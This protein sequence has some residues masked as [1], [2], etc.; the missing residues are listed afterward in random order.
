MGFEGRIELCSRRVIE[1]G[2]YLT[3]IH[4]RG[5]TLGFESIGEARYGR[6]IV[7]RTSRDEEADDEED[8]NDQDYNS[9]KKFPIGRRRQRITYARNVV[10]PFDHTGTIATRVTADTIAHIRTGILSFTVVV[11]ITCRTLLHLRESFR[12]ST[13]IRIPVDLQGKNV[14]VVERKRTIRT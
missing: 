3:T 6:M 5:Q 11:E 7:L 4:I 2:L 12:Y 13:R 14:L 9:H 8:H 10:R 1:C